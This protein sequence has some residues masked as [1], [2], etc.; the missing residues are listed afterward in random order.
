MQ[1]V[2]RSVATLAVL[3]V[4]GLSSSF[5]ADT[6]I[7]ISKIVSHPALDAVEK[8]IQDE[9][10]ALG[11][12]ARYDLQ[13][14]NGDGTAAGS[15]AAKFKNDKVTV[16]VGIAT[17]TAQALV[18]AIKDIPV[19]YSAVT[20]PVSAKLVASYTAG[21]ENVTGVSD[22]INVKDQ[23][24][25]LISLK[26][27]IKRIGHIY[28]AGEQNARVLADETKA[29]CIA[30]GLEFVPSTVTATAEV[31]TAAESLTGRVDAFYVSTD[32]MV[33]SALPA[34]AKVAKLK[35]LP[36]MS[37]DPTS[38]VN[39]ATAG[40]GFDYY[41]MGRVTGKLIADILKGKKTSEIATQYLTDPK[42]L[43]LVLNLDYAKDIGITYSAETLAKA[44][45]VVKDGKEQANN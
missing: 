13:N 5:A 25:L 20:D 29:A 18:R 2:L 32:N 39:G 11:I 35:K 33:I 45:R 24:S 38:V 3:A 44:A 4:F 23:L 22:M 28:N 31:R 7:G 30:L 12:V 8:G 6:V 21:G 19:V 34:I 9:L 26:P 1:K 42:D 27:G 43:D 10:K 14:A 36:I 16:A 17:P 40:L 41:K 37:A 15:I